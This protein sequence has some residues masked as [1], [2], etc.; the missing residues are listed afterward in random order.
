MAKPRRKVRPEP[1]ANTWLDTIIE[2][3]V[4]IV[5]HLDRLIARDQSCHGNDAAVSW[6]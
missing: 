2:R 5:W 3:H 1:A 4:E 6:R